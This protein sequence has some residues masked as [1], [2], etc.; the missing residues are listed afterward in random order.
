[1]SLSVSVPVVKRPQ[2]AVVTVSVI[3]SYASGIV[4][5]IVSVSKHVNMGNRTLGILKQY[6]YVGILELTLPK[7]QS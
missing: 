5:V 1:M 6:T 2:L 4:S 3:V 7:D